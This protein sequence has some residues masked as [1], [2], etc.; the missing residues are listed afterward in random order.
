MC[1]AMF[2][3][4]YCCINLCTRKLNRIYIYKIFFPVNN[5][6]FKIQIARKLK[7]PYFKKYH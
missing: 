3:I 7:T 5:E 1:D 4:E 2:I 6:P